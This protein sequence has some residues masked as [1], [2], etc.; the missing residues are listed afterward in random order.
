MNESVIVL[1]LNVQIDIQM[2]SHI[3]HKGREVLV[4]YQNDITIYITI[5]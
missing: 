1:K 3:F 4:E 5:E 2:A